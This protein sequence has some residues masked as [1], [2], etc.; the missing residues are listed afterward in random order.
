MATFPVA[1]ANGHNISGDIAFHISAEQTYAVDISTSSGTGAGSKLIAVAN[2]TFHTF[3][4]G[5]APC[6][7]SASVGNFFCK[8]I[9]RSVPNRYFGE[10]GFFIISDDNK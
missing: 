3:A 1:G 7:T 5:S 4:G 2:G 8:G 9:G 10:N 6:G